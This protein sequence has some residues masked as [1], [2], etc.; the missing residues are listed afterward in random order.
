MNKESIRH[1]V[2]IFMPVYL[3][4]SESMSLIYAGYSPIKRNY[5]ARL[6]LNSNYDRSFLGWYWFS[7]LPAF[8]KSHNIDVIVSEISSNTFKWFQIRGGFIL[9]VWTTTRINVERPMSE[10]CKSNV[11]DFPNV[12]RRI[13]K[14][15]LTPEIL[16]GKENFNLFIE[17]YYLPYITRRHG[18]EAFIED[19]SKIWK[20]LDSP[21][22][23]AIKENGIIIA[24]SMLVKSGDSLHFKRLGL[25]EGNDEYRLHGA[26]GA[27]YYFGIIEA[28]KM[29]CR[30]FDLGGTRPFLTDGL[31]KYKLGLGAEFVQNL[32]PLKE[33][34]WFG[35]NGNS[36][37]ASDFLSANPFMFVGKDFTLTRYTADDLN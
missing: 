7:K 22:F 17:K 33:Y 36:A 18:Q 32:S 16:S 29:K 35:V 31:T 27:L 19:M 15:N 25:L 28:Q 26:I 30:Y 1:L 9:P 2:R 20:T 13:R 6:I 8:F 24:M 4:K 23:L 10:I 14:Y 37:A 12:T 21:F 34:V 11:T 5:Y 3:C